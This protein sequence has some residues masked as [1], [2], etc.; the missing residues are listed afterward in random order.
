MSV[1]NKTPIIVEDA[2]YDPKD[3]M[4]ILIVRLKLT[5]EKKILINPKSAYR[6]KDGKPG[7]FP[8][9]EMYKTA[10]LYKGK[11]FLWQH[12]VDVDMQQ[13]NAETAERLSKNVG[14]QM[15]EITNILSE[16]KHIVERKKED[17]ERIKMIEDV[18]NRIKKDLNK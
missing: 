17:F 5:G 8:D 6:W 4:L 12:I 18:R 7:D 15:K 3:Q 11:S 10:K 14:E 13:I 16:D 1:S 9:R 2:I